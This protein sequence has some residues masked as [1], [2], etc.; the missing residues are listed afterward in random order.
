MHRLLVQIEAGAMWGRE[1]RGVAG[2]VLNEKAYSYE[3][4][5]IHFPVNPDPGE[6]A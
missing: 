4:E 2:P 5:P 1:M 6:R 3:L